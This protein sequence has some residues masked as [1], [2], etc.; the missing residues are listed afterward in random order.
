MQHPLNNW[1]KSVDNRVPLIQE[2][3]AAAIWRHVPSQS[4]PV[5]LISDG[6]E[7]TAFSTSTLWWKGP[8]RLT[9]QP[10][11]CPKTE[12]NTPKCNLETWYVYLPCLQTAEFITQIFSKFNRLSRV[13]AYWRGI[14]ITCRHSEANRLST[15]LSTQDLD[16]SL[17]CCLKMVQ[18][19]PYALEIKDLGEKKVVAVNSSLKNLH[20]FMEN[21]GLIRVGV[22][23]QHSKITYQKRHQTI[24]PT[25]PIFKATCPI[26]GLTTVQHLVFH[27]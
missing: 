4:N 9:Q 25:K 3:S 18:Q 20:L 5:D 1:K 22:R 21:E 19:V 27:I 10:S 14:V 7:P 6:I 17:T 11:S 24:L 13:I 8:Q 23:L 16:Q 12:V 26:T 15:T 2:E